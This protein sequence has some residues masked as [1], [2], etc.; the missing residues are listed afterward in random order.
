LCGVQEKVF[1]RRKDTMNTKLKVALLEAG[2]KQWELAR[3]V[4]L[5]AH[6]VSDLVMG[7]VMPTTVEKQLIAR[8]LHRSG[9]DISRLYVSVRCMTRLRSPK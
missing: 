5:S 6:R 7:R 9:E 8:A 2:K 4:G 3:E 1:F